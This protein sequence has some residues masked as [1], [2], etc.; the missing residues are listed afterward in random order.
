MYTSIFLRP[1]YLVD[2]P[3]ICKDGSR[4]DLV[5][6]SDSWVP[7]PRKKEENRTEY[8][9]KF[10]QRSRTVFC[11]VAATPIDACNYLLR[12]AMKRAFPG[13]ALLR[14]KPIYQPSNISDLIPELASMLGRCGRPPCHAR[15]GRAEVGAGGEYEWTISAG[16]TGPESSSSGWPFFFSRGV[17]GRAAYAARWG[18][19]P[20]I[21]V[22]CWPSSSWPIRRSFPRAEPAPAVTYGLETAH[23][24]Q[25]HFCPPSIHPVVVLVSTLPRAVGVKKAKSTG[26]FLARQPG[27]L[28]V[29]T[30]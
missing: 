22:A 14:T 19:H 6:E 16:E 30:R 7:I 27:Q 23:T 24:V 15:R 4:C 11:N 1:L 21:E 25:C 26:S 13:R 28:F 18:S 12:E 20:K 10:A 3:S 17:P 2:V 29:G 5:R 9:S 8:V